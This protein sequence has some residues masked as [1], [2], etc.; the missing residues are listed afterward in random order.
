LAQTV[1]SIDG[2]AYDR[3]T[4]AT[5]ANESDIGREPASGFVKI[6][7][8]RLHYL[9]WGGD[10]PPILILHATGFL[11]RIYRPI[12]EALRLIGHVYSY[13]QRGHGD[14]EIPS[15]DAISWDETANDLEG[16]LIAMG[17]KSA[18]AVGHSAGGTA[19]GTV[20]ARRPDL[21]A[22]AVL[23]E[24]VLVD[25]DDPRERP[26]DLRERTLKRRRSFDS[27]DAMFDNFA[28]KPPYQT[29]RR[30]ILKD[31]CECGTK[32]DLDG[33]R[34]LK[35]PPEIE[36]QIYATARDFDGLSY[37]LRS[38]APTLVMFGR[39]SDSP[40]ILAAERLRAPHRRV[41]VL[42][43]TTHFIPM[44]EPQMAARTA[45]EFLSGE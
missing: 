45:A 40:G 33:R 32:P 11:G 3:P 7:G 6:N 41:E 17:F 14:S 12:A 26:N 35:C 18:R 30:D 39:D 44:E 8:L 10:G 22:R 23:M 37:L 38:A 1:F 13:D 36:A 15:V 2:L 34:V 21:I 43:G 42:P 31:Y 25:P 16:F 5:S 24:P 29:W 20:A 19:I 28:R 4:M 27:V 9:D